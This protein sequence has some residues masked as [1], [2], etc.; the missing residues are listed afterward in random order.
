LSETVKRRR[1]WPWWLLVT[2]LLLGS[3]WIAWRFRPLNATERTLVGRWESID[4][5]SLYEFA[6]SRRFQ[7]TNPDSRVATMQGLWSATDSSLS[8]RDHVPRAKFSHL[9]WLKRMRAYAVVTF[10]PSTAEVRW[11]SPDRFEMYGYEFARI[12]DEPPLADRET[13]PLE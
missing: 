1:R 6:A 8:F 7:T 13:T 12:P 11:H 2:V 9:P 10:L 4:D 3:G 5:G